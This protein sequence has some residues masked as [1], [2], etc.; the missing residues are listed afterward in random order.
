MDR[1]AYEHYLSLFNARNYE[2]VLEHFVP[3]FEIRVTDQIRLRG[4]EQMLSFYSFLHEHLVEFI[5]LDNFAASD[6]LTAV[7]ARVCLRCTKAITAQ[8]LAARGLKG[9]FAMEAGQELEVP[10][11]LHY[12]LKDGKITDVVC[13]VVMP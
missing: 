9:M 2:A 5:K 1:T 11:Y 6:T 3:D 12:H 10:Q 8:A 7:E 4:R 13:V